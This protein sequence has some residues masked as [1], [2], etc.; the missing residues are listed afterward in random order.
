[1]SLSREA[2]ITLRAP[3]NPTRTP[4]PTPNWQAPLLTFLSGSWA[5]THST[6]A[7]RALT[8]RNA[9]ITL[10]LNPTTQNFTTS[11]TSQVTT[12]SW[13]RGES[14]TDVSVTGTA[15]PSDLKDGKASEFTFKL[16]SASGGQGE[17][18][19]W[20]VLAW[21]KEG[22]LEKWMLEEE[23]GW[24]GD[25]SGE[26]RGDWRDSYVVVYRHND[27]EKEKRGGEEKEEGGLEGVVEVWDRWG[28]SPSG[29]LT[30]ETIG[31]IRDALKGVV[32]EGELRVVP[33][34]VDCTK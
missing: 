29:G 5:I 3:P 9:R 8:H 13:W 7:H 2:L 11:E 24:I 16:E 31:K 21:G 18:K 32:V 19:S 15:S 17:G 33:T 25:G 26:R 30:G 23:G 6:S 34:G 10:T 12:S 20:S 22:Q 4:T 28:G 14:N 1:M 27:S